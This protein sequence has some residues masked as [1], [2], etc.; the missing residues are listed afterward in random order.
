MLWEILKDKFDILLISEMKTDT[1]FLFES[2]L[3]SF[4]SLFRPDRNSLG[5]GIILYFTKK[6]ENF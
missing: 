2:F 4:S 5:G 1:F 3:D 6:I